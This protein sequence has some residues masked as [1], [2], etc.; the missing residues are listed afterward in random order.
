MKRLFMIALLL[1]IGLVQ[2]VIAGTKP[3]AGL[4]DYNGT[5]WG[6]PNTGSTAY[7][8][9]Y[10]S[11][12]IFTTLY[13]DNYSRTSGCAGEG[14]GKHPGVDIAVAS[15]TPVVA[16]LGGT[17]VEATCD[18]NRKR[19]L[20]NRAQGF[21]GL[22]IIESDNPYASGK[23]YVIY[24]HLD[25]WSV[26]SVGQTV[27][28]G[29]IIGYSGGDDVT[30]VCPGASDGAHLHFQVDKF[31]PT[32]N[33]RE[34]LTPWF[35]TGRV[36][37]AD[38]NFEVITK[39]HNPLPFVLGY[40]YN[41][42]FAENN[43]KELWGAANVNDYNTEN[44]DLWVDSESAYP[45]VGRSS[46]FGN[47]S[48]CSEPLPNAP[49]SRE[50]TLDA[51]IFKW[52]VL[53]LD[54]KCYNNPVIIY[55]RGSDDVW[56]AGSFNYDTAQKYYLNMSSLPDWNGIVSDLILRPSQGCIASPGP[57]EYFIKQ[58]YFLP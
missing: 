11:T 28:E 50:I 29:E 22:V 30:G 27:S 37:T 4:P 25:N 3:I 56:H 17:V 2:T 35:P 6:T 55:Y 39:T 48:S 10:R 47:A 33:S 46:F 18:W 49:C 52:L 57:E 31:A 58:M 16:A 42:T 14:C 43:N 5:Y 36:E 8:S 9:L 1:T 19:G 12:P 45:Y 26:Y 38:S 54:F 51:D 24:A 20:S 40:A 41:Y 34:K 13:R 15:G 23:V 7:D 32:I 44:S 21:G 53:R